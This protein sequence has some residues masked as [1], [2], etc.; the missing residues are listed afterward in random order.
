MAL[1]FTNTKTFARVFYEH[2]A[3]ANTVNLVSKVL[4]T[5]SACTQITALVGAH[6]TTKYPRQKKWI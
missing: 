6:P 3:C 5:N 1:L 4:S 2:C